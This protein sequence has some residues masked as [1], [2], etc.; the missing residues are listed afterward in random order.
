MTMIAIS[1]ITPRD[2]PTPDGPVRHL[3][4]MAGTKSCRPVLLF[5]V[6]PNYLNHLAWKH[7]KLTSGSIV[8]SV[9]LH[10]LNQLVWKQSNYLALQT[11]F[12]LFTA[13]TKVTIAAVSDTMKCQVMHSCMHRIVSLVSSIY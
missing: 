12:T 4:K 7:K 6:C 11:L 1:T 3:N 13:V 10:Y 8:P 5:L 9:R 2:L